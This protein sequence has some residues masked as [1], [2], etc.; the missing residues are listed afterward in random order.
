MG[1]IILI[2]YNLVL[3]IGL[4]LILNELML[5]K[6]QETITLL[7]V[8]FFSFITTFLVFGS[9]TA[10]NKVMVSPRDILLGISLLMTFCGLFALLILIR[11]KEKIKFKPIFLWLISL[12]VILLLIYVL[13]RLL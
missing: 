5:H 4:A 6:P 11:I 10:L 2:I 9:I 7:K 12:P 3:Y 1:T 8:G 13:Y